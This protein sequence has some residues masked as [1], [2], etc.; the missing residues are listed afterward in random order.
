[1]LN[2]KKTIKSIIIIIFSI[3]CLI[4][5]AVLSLYRRDLSI[6]ELKEYLITDYS[7]IIPVTIHDLNSHK[8]I[9]IDIHYYDSDNTNDQTIVLLHG[10]FSSLHTFIDAA[11]LLKHEGYRVILIDLPGH[12]LS[13]HFEDNMVSL[14]RS[15][16]IVREILNIESVNNCIIGG[17]SMGGGVSWYF[18]SAYNNIDGFKVKALILIDAVY[19]L[20]PDE[21]T[22]KRGGKSIIRLLKSNPFRNITYRMTP[23]LLIKYLLDSVYGTA[24]KPDSKTI[25]RYYFMLRKTGNREALLNSNQDITCP[26]YIRG[27]ELLESIAESKIP[28]LIIWGKQDKWI[29]VDLCR[30]FQETLNLDEKNIRIYENSGHAPMEEEPARFYD[31]LLNFIK[32]L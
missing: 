2:S 4:I 19:P 28:V 9:T 7:Q 15:A 32:D 30:R 6:N 10:M 17:N 26:A 20:A 22:G 18:T 11:N 12:G 31:D 29:N 23:R 5:I 24:S 27:E 13:G 21:N 14:S 25:D 3:L 1:M 16:A 8:D